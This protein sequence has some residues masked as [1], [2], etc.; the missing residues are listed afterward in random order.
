MPDDAASRSPMQAAAGHAIPIGKS[1]LFAAMVVGNVLLA[2]GCGYAFRQ[3][4]CRGWEM[5]PLGVLLGQLVLTSLWNALGGNWG[6]LRY[7]LICLALTGGSILFVWGTVSTNFEMAI[8]CDM[9]FAAAIVVFTLNCLLSP[10]RWLL[11]WRLDFA[12]A[13]HEVRSAG[14]MQLGLR[15][16][17]LCP[18]VCTAPLLAYRCMPSD[19][20][21]GIALSILAVGLIAA[22]PAL[23]VAACMFGDQLSRRTRGGLLTVSATL[24]AMQYSAL[25][26]DLIGEPFWQLGLST[27]ATV[28][29]NL[30]VARMIGIR[31]LYIP[32]ATAAPAPGLAYAPSA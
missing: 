28:A 23:P 8:C 29:I 27:V 18:L 25:G 7:A 5:I 9:I 2:G 12:L 17:L 31:W 1:A 16:L 26:Y 30:T 20:A 11:G 19:D 24:L 22:L 14:R 32:R 10:L 3:E 21:P 4:L 13:A 6:P 15:E